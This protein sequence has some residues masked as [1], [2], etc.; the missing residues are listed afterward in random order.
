[1]AKLGLEASTHWSGL[2]T[3][4][5]RVFRALCDLTIAQ[6]EQA[7]GGFTPIEIVQAVSLIDRRWNSPSAREAAS[8]N[9]RDKMNSLLEKWPSYTQGL[10]QA[11][12]KQ[13]LDAVPQPDVVGGGGAGNFT[14]Y[15][16]LPVPM[17]HEAVSE[18][19]PASLGPGEIA[20]VPAEVRSLPAWL[21]TVMGAELRSTWGRR[22]YLS[23]NIATISLVLF[24]IWL[25]FSS[26]LL[27]GGRGESLVVAFAAM[28]IAAVVWMKL[29]PLYLVILRRAVRAPG[30]I[31]D[32][33]GSRILLAKLP[34][35]YQ[36][37]RIE[38]VRFAATCCVPGCGG[39]VTVAPGWPERPGRLVGRCDQAP[40][41]HVYSFDHVTGLGRR[42]PD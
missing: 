39:E 5:V 27:G 7:K 30:W 11:A 4:P 8:K 36:D 14:R 18:D 22:V 6:P 13:G 24:L 25:A 26:V 2:G 42:L 32:D 41:V 9:V 38:L 37:K 28:A 19:Q 34:P 16:L 12:R 3:L 15:R 33:E 31:Q 23:L 29:G 10:Q 21:R 1:M 17:D 40:R 35:K 20:Y